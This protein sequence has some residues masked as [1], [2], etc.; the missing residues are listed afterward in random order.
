MHLRYL[1]YLRLVVEHGSFAAAALAGGVTQP[2]I[3]HG[4]RQL[5]RS[6][7]VPLFERQG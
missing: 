6:F 5:Q 4:I 2:A 3:S 1:H 7:D